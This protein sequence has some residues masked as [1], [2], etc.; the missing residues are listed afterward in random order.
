MNIQCR[1]IVIDNPAALP[2]DVLPSPDIKFGN[3]AGEIPNLDIFK[4]L[5]D[6]FNKKGA[7]LLTGIF[8][9]FLRGRTLEIPVIAT[10]GIR[11][12]YDAWCADHSGRRTVFFNL[13][14]WTADDLKKSGLA[15]VIHEISHVL[16]AEAAS[17]TPDTQNPLKILERLV[18]D[19]GIAH[20]IGF[21]GDREKLL[22]D[23]KGKWPRAEAGLKEAIAKLSDPQISTKEKE[24]ILTAANTGS[25]WDKYASIAGLFRAANIYRTKGAPGLI[26]CI[27]GGQLPDLDENCSHCQ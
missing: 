6:D 24:D 26:E 19:E 14:L 20:F 23:Y 16:L 21:P 1:L 13:S 2:S 22:T 27:K 17:K 8:S 18:F 15:V 9:P 3:C 25:F 11:E 7:S 4:A 12:P 10:Q 5:I